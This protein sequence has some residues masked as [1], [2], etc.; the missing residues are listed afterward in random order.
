MKTLKRRCEQTSF[1]NFERINVFYSDFFPSGKSV[2][3]I[4]KLS[5]PMKIIVFIHNKP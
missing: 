1:V 5:A 2:G 3:S 4:N